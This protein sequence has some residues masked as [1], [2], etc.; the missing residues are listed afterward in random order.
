MCSPGTL[1]C[2]EKQRWEAQR[3]R[4]SHVEHR[5]QFWTLHAQPFQERGL[6]RRSEILVECPLSVRAEVAQIRRL[7]T[8][9]EPR[10]APE[11]S[12][13]CIPIPRERGSHPCCPRD[14]V[15]V[16]R[17]REGRE[18]RI[19]DIEACLAGSQFSFNIPRSE[20]FKFL[21]SRLAPTLFCIISHFFAT[22]PLQ[23]ALPQAEAQHPLPH[24]Y[25]RYHLHHRTWN[26]ALQPCTQSYPR[27]ELR[28]ARQYRLRLVFQLRECRNHVRELAQLLT[29]AECPKPVIWPRTILAGDWRLSAWL[30][31]LGVIRSVLC[32]A[33]LFR[34]ASQLIP[35]SH[36]QTE[37]DAHRLP[38]EELRVVRHLPELHERVVELLL[39]SGAQDIAGDNLLPNLCIQTPLHGAEWA[40][41]LALLFLA[42]LRGD[43][44]LLASQ[45]ERT[46]NFVQTAELL[47]A[48]PDAPR[49]GCLHVAPEP[50]G[51][52]LARAEDAGHDEVEERPELGEGVLDGRSRQQNLVRR[53]VLH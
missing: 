2:G 51:E 9:T 20:L 12:G 41:K 28:L 53:P 44:L 6:R 8:L 15:P 1:D 29:L 11:R 39:G 13:T 19:Q 14:R 47:G 48:Q 25:S 26:H 42:Q 21:S 24:S 27:P 10:L 40:Q 33:R 49:G 4:R 36:V 37:R 46:Q 23:D 45:H 5:C 34:S 32:V 18:E 43:V 38:P 31:Y 50:L 17:T 22:Q 3:A 35:L 7:G 30:P 16:D 52:A